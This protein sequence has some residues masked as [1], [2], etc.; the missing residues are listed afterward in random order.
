MRF[1]K[2]VHYPHR[3]GGPARRPY[4]V[5]EAARRARRLNLSKTRMRSSQ[6]ILTIKLRIW[7]DTFGNGPHLSQRELA[8]QLGVCPSYIHKVQHQGA[9]AVDALTRGQRV[10][11]DDL[12]AARRF[13][14]RLRELEPGLLRVVGSNR[15]T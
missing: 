5:S 8:R 1:L 3:P 6:E 11:M 13:T 14:A 12:A 7:Q 4:H 15:I 9:E 10:T 2:G